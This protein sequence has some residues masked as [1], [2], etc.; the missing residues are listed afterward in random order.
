MPDFEA[1]VRFLVT[2]F[3]ESPDALKLNVEPLA[4][5]QRLWVRVAFDGDDKGRVFG[6]GGRNIQ[7]IRQVLKATGTLHGCSVNLDVYGESSQGSGDGSDRSRPR[8]GRGGGRPRRDSVSRPKPK[9][10]T[11]R[12]N[13]Q[14][15]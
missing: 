15:T 3:L 9:A 10:P 14:D 8:G 12:R 5:G 2:P 4:D 13:D 6:R 7:A 1:L 11:P